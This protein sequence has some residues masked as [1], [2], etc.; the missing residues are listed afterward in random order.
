MYEYFLAQPQELQMMFHDRKERTCA[1]VTRWNEIK[2]DRIYLVGSGTSFHSARAVADFMETFLGVEVTVSAPSQ[3]SHIH[4]IRPLLVYLSQSGTSTNTVRAAFN[5]QGIPSIAVTGEDASELTDIV[6][7][8]AHMGIQRETAGPK[9][10]GY[11]SSVLFLYL[12]A[13]EAAQTDK[14]AATIRYQETIDEL[15]R[16]IHTMPDNITR[17][18]TWFQ[19]NS[20]ELSK[21]RKYVIVGQGLGGLV[22]GEG[23]LKIL[24]TVRVPASGYEFEEYLHGP[25]LQT[26]DDLGGIYFIPNDENQRW[27]QA[28][29]DLHKTASPYVYI[30]TGMRDEHDTSRSLILQTTGNDYTLPFEYILPCQIM[31]ALLPDLTGRNQI[32]NFLREYQKIHPLKHRLD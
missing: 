15:D 22:A 10:I 17:T 28:L 1:F 31:G 3:L 18:L 26:D 30:V 4:G 24:E 12:C 9:T 8:H 16:A 25:I 21:I 23:A 32:R 29:A 20:E 6:G 11:T 14:N 19:N 27:V 13:L 7:Y 2:P 5:Y